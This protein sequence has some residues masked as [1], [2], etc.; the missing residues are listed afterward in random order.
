MVSLLRPH[1][2]L[3]TK[4][5]QL[6]REKGTLQLRLGKALSDLEALSRSAVGG[7]GSVLPSA[8]AAEAADAVLAQKLVELQKE[9]ARLVSENKNMF[10]L[11]EENS[12]LKAEAEELRLQVLQSRGEDAEDD[13]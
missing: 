1:R 12:R 4:C 7:V 8:G 5:D 3:L 13:P 9:N 2:V 6:M 11:L 10:W